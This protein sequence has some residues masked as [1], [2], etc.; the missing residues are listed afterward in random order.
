MAVTITCEMNVALNVKAPYKLVFDTLSD[1]PGSATHYP[2]V[3][4][5]IDEGDG[6]YRWEMEKVGIGS[7]F[8]QTVYASKYVSNPATGIISWTPVKGVGNSLVK[9]E[10]KIK[11]MKKHT[12]IAMTVQGEFTIPAPGL[13]KMVLSSLVKSEFDKMTNVY[14]ENL[15]KFFGGAA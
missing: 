13:M 15:T 6:V 5:L 3:D 12:N 14:L 2:K 8:L 9:G 1:V 4:K 11:D 7:F 10:W